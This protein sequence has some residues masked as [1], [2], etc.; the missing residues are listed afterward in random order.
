MFS[1]NQNKE[2]M[3]SEKDQNIDNLTIWL[4]RI[5]CLIIIIFFSVLLISIPILVTFLKSQ[6]SNYLVNLKEILKSLLE[7]SLA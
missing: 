7:A 1:S 6:L 2:V 3:Q 5:A 4:I